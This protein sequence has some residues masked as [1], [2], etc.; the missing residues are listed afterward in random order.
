[1]LSG[2]VCR[3]WPLLALPLAAALASR[4]G[5]QVPPNAVQAESRAAEPLRMRPGD[6]IRVLVW[7]HPELSGDFPIDE[8]Y[9][10][11]YPIIGTIGLENVTVAELRSRLI[12]DL[13]QLFRQPFVTVT[14]LFRVAALGEVFR[15]GLLSV[16]PTLTVLEILALAGGLTPRGNQRDIRLLRG[17]E[18]IPVAYD[19]AALAQATLRELGIRSGDQVFVPRKGFTREDLNILVGIGNLTVSL[20]SLIV[21]L[22][23]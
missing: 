2:R 12:N 19:R 6:V 5:A 20:V 15:P 21:L 8:N 9:Q 23:R 18:E 14:P 4:A 16:D 13:E 11:L 22:I 3:V 10:L 1:M 7:A 17:G